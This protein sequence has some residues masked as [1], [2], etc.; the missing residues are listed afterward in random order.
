MTSAV[1][2]P[3]PRPATASRTLR[4]VTD[5]LAAGL[6]T[7]AQVP[8]LE[9]V[10]RQYATAI[11]PAFAD[12]IE[13]PDDPIGRQ[14][15][16]DGAEIHT[17]TTEDPDPIG[18]DAL[19][20]V[21][22]IVHRY[23][24]RA[25]LKPLLVCPLYCRFCFRREHVGPGGGVLDDAALEHAL[26]WLRTHTGIHEVVMTGGDPLMLSARRMRAIMQA[27]EGM[28]HIHTIRIHSRVPVADPGRLDDEMADALETTRSMWLVVHVNHARELTPQAHAAI[29]R[30]QARAIPVLGQSVLLRGVN[31]TPQA[32][33]ALLRAQVAARIRPYYLH[34][35]DPAPG[36]ARFHVPIREG[37]RLLAS[38]RGRVTGIAWPTY[39][40]DIPGGH[41]KVPIAP[42]YLHE[43]PD[44]TLH[45]TAPDGTIHRLAR[46]RG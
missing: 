30:V 8:A 40:L 7:P 41:G 1:N 32:L 29:R 27:L 34:Q 12:L 2:P 15:I 13:T 46:E 20:P 38:L 31:D 9:D 5:L 44:G 10:A 33:E 18:D 36:T 19:S 22:G 42:G 11:P 39:V 24:D 16:P 28:D 17:D 43:G 14:V 21:P 45:A 23:A 25:L 6:V 3:P 4:S 37:Q 35:L 26:D